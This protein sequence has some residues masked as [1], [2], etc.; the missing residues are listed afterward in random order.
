MIDSL[1]PGLPLDNE[2]GLRPEHE[3][4]QR[5]WQY[6]KEAA[7]FIGIALAVIG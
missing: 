1:F 5:A 6:I 4:A 7:P 3:Y 2:R